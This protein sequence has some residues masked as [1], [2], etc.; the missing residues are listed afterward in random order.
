MSALEWRQIGWQERRALV[1]GLREE[2]SDDEDSTPQ[3]GT[4]NNL[5]AIGITVKAA[6]EDA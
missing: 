2:F 3:E 6:G 5:S 4:P 1:E